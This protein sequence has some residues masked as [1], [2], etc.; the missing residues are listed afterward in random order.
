[1]SWN[2]TG[3]LVET[4]NCNMLC[5][6]WFGQAD[7]M[8]LDQGYC[9]TSLLLRVNEGSHNGVDISGQNAIANL[10]F[11]GP[12]LFDGNGTGRIFVDTGASD[13]QANALEAILQGG[14]GG[15]MEVPA[16]L[17]SSWLPTKRSAITV[18]E[19]DGAISAN[20]E[21]IGEMSS[22]RLVNELGKTMSLH[23]SVFS[24][25]FGFNDHIGDLAPSDGTAWNDPDMPEVWKGRSGV[26]GQIS[27]AG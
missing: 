26:V 7:L 6:C 23:N 19:A 10:H 20:V 27:W 13:A 9:A 12:T 8:L 5:P 4:C 14:S 22:K 17:L 25:A 1:M 15:G 24:M 3:E 18:S 2:L 16:S 21:G 11:P